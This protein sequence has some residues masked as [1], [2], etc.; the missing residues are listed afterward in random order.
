MKA[1][2]KIFF[3]FISVSLSSCTDDHAFKADQ[4]I[5]AWDLTS[6]TR[7]GAATGTLD[8]V[9]YEFDGNMR[10]RTNLPLPG[11]GENWTAFA[12]KNAEIVLDKPGMIKKYAVSELGPNT[13]TL[14]FDIQGSRFVMKLKKRE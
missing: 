5:G 3:L 12:L 1:F 8:G 6:A 10:M 9:F 7:D 4:L 2:G 14:S 13:L 11:A